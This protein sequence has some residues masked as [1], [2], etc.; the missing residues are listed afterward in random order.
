MENNHFF[1]LKSEHYQGL[2]ALHPP[3]HNRSTI[4]YRSIIILDICFNV[5]IQTNTRAVSG[6]YWTI[7]CQKARRIKDSGDVFRPVNTRYLR[8]I[9]R[10]L[11]GICFVQPR[12]RE[13]SP[14]IPIN[15][16]DSNHPLIRLAQSPEARVP[17]QPADEYPTFCHHS[18]GRRFS[19]PRKLPKYPEY[20]RERLK[21]IGFHHFFA[22]A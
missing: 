19:T 22:S 18:V 6:I 8:G 11:R 5:E 3:P 17:V 13:C 4:L 14:T 15:N 21:P 20:S 7:K 10:Y 16:P 12:S 2:Q 1:W 9:Y